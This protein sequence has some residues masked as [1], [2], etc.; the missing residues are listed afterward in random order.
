MASVELLSPAGDF[1]ALEAAVS[2][3]ADAVYLGLEDFNARRRAEN[4]RR[5]D[6]RRVVAFCHERGVKA[7]LTAN[8]LVRNDE[9]G[10]YFKLIE[11]AYSAGVDA[12]IVQELSFA[13]ILK[14]SFPDLGVHASTQAGVFNS[15]FRRALDGIDR[16]IL[17]REMTLNQ[18]KEF[19]VRTGIPVEVFVQ[20]ALCFS[21][22]GQCLMSSFLGGRSGNRGWCAQPCRKKYNGVYLLST[23]D[24][25]V[26]ERVKAV[27]DAGVSALKIEGRLR[28]PEYVGAATALYRRALDEG[29]V[30]EDAL[31]DLTLAFSREFTRGALFREFDVVSG[32][33]AG[34]R[35][36]H[37]GRMMK[38]GLIR[39][40]CEL[41][42]V[43]GVGVRTRRGAHGDI[44]RGIYLREK[45][46]ERGLPGQT[47]K[48]EVNATEGDEISLTSGV[49]RRKTRS[50]AKKR[51]ITVS[52]VQRTAVLPGVSAAGLS[53][54]RLL[55]KAYS[56]DDALA[57]VDAGASR[58]YY[59]I[60]EEDYPGGFVGAYIP[61]CL[62]EWS[63][64]KAV[65][66]VERF[67][68]T[69]L[70]CGDLGVASSIHA[71]EVYLDVSC[72]AFNDYDVAYYNSLGLTPII[73]PEL[74]IENLKGFRDKRFAVYAHG[75]IPLMTT[76]Y[77]LDARK[78]RDER[79]Y[80][81][82][83]RGEGEC[84]QVLNSVP[85]GFFHKVLTLRDCGVT[86]F[87]LDAG[88]DAAETVSTYRR[89]LA[90][91]RVKKPTGYTLGNYA[92]GVL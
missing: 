90:G 24:L 59:N 36:I 67:N 32:E 13:P 73:S 21:I 30:D 27:V 86:A 18:V 57:A 34:K 39:L 5:G 64:R 83:V 52:R 53:G 22:S 23:R 41:R 19:R 91:E 37:V 42:V 12:V 72:N 84:K 66:L 29:R 82:P 68:P 33:E 26:A 16:V 81:F 80:V 71:D 9:L 44:I 47:V 70:L 38:G 69:S 60:F 17:P 45:K 79:G 76:K 20:G 87:L 48:L 35:G 40:S 2:E 49:V 74:S 92:R 43:D 63:A 10:E 6:L 61:R 1:K 46:V 88:E 55:A 54:V 11:I 51:G 75:R 25:C 58:A 31:T 28:S 77:R 85:L 3:G 78:L 4:V 8:T 56:V 15:F 62:S 50:F 7:Y 14:A 89:I 65:D